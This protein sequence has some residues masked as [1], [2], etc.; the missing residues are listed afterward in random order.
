MLAV[1]AVLAGGVIVVPSLVE[2]AGGHGA[3]R[4][5]SVA[6]ITATDPATRDGQFW[7]IT[8]SGFGV[9]ITGSRTAATS[10]LVSDTMTLFVAV[11][12]SQP[13]L[14]VSAP[15][16][17]VRQVGGPPLSAA[18]IAG[19]LPGPGVSTASP[20]N[21]GDPSDLWR[22]PTPSFLAGLPRDPVALAARIRATG[23]TEGGSAAGLMFA[24]ASLVLHSG[25]VPADLR[26]ALYRV[27]AAAPGVVVTAADDDVAGVHGVGFSRLDADSGLRQEIVVDPETGDVVGDRQVAT[28][29]LD[30]VPAGTVLDERTTAR[31]L[32]DGVPATVDAGGLVFH[33]VTASDGRVT[34]RG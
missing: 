1:A 7:Q 23:D 27:L 32:V 8:T 21:P 31:R 12:G 29:A 24:T 28:R 5:G 3:V 9:T 34:C 11:D 22:A 30:G 20:A 15:S 6:G 18:E 2:S 25:L 13:T 10:L 17:A 26:A 14:V 33:C 4:V 19:Q 16:R